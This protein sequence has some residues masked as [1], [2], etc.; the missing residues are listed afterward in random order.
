MPTVGWIQETNIERYWEHPYPPERYGPPEIPCGFCGR[1]FSSSDQLERHLG[2]DHPVSI[3]VLY[4]GAQQA[5]PELSIRTPVQSDDIALLNCTACE[6]SRDGGPSKPISPERLVRFLAAERS[7]RC[8]LTL[9]NERSLDRS[10]AVAQFVV[11]FSVPNRDAL[12]AIDKDFIERFAH[13]EH[14]RIADVEGFRTACPSERPAQEYA[15][16][17]GDYVI[18]LA[19]KERHPE[20]GSLLEFEHYK[21][22][23]TGALGVLKQ[24]HRPVSRA[25]TSVI[26]FNLNNFVV[27]PAPT[28]LHSLGVAFAFFRAIAQGQEP[29]S[30]SRGSSRHT[31]ICPVDIVTHRILDAARRLSSTRKPHALLAAELEELSRWQP[32]SEYDT[33]KIQVMSATAQ[34][35][36]GNATAAKH[37]R[38]AWAS[39]R[40]RRFPV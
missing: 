17:L 4:I 16:A 23:F 13:A 19:I 15:S 2:L 6:I 5:G 10:K 7:S 35:R 11:R 27:S 26:D 24:F 22:K 12:N 37:H 34:L 32:L 40:G 28:K 30:V 21:E 1:V 29:A 39:S 31:S 25:V 36:L 20:G 38:E 8:T 9:I 14:P 33:T 18:G 3:P